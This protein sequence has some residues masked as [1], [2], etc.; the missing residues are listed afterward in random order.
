MDLHLLAIPAV[1]ALVGWG[2]NV[3]AIK[4][5]FSPL[6]RVGW[7]TLG[8]QGV[9]P[10]NAERMATICVR[11]MTEKLLDIE[12][13]FSRIDS[14]Q[15]STL[16]SPALE[17]NAE[18]IVED[19]LQQRFP[20]VWESLPDRVRKRARARLQSE[21]PL[22]V[23]KL[24]NELSSDLRRYL[25]IEALVVGAF[26]KNRALLNQLFWEC[27]ES[28]FRF[29]GRSGLYFGDIRIVCCALK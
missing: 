5:L 23:D 19:V 27:G 28:E 26:V 25:D 22:V 2:T 11:L 17:K 13:V 20:T 21:V 12:A 10:A 6:Q 15:I 16:L 8:W 9:L 1:T 4:M 18:E 29:I 14:K 24:M 7:K 3:I